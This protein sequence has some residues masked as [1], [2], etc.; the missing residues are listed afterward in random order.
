MEAFS[1]LGTTLW[2]SSHCFLRI[3]ALKMDCTTLEGTIENVQAPGI[4]RFQ[5]TNSSRICESITQGTRV[6]AFHTIQATMRGCLGPCSSCSKVTVLNWL[7][8]GRNY[9]HWYSEW[10]IAQ[11]YQVL[12]SFRLWTRSTV[13]EFRVELAGAKTNTQP[14]CLCFK[15][16]CGFWKTG[17]V[18]SYASENDIRFRVTRSS[19]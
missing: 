1:F 16:P 19:L 10:K 9:H 17:P 11:F 3:E 15:P 14:S 7:E 18:E 8:Q 5:H 13:A 2:Q 6:S 4:H 12:Q